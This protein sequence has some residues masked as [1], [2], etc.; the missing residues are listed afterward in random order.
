MYIYEK[1]P[2]HGSGDYHGWIKFRFKDITC[3]FFY[4]N[5]V[6]LLCVF[7]LHYEKCNTRKNYQGLET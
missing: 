6:S 7:F 4:G 1:I 2:L 5:F 3:I